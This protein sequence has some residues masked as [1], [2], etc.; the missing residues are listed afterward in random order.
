MTAT[1]TTEYK[2]DIHFHCVSFTSDPAAVASDMYFTNIG[3]A[4]E[5][6]EHKVRHF[7]SVMLWERGHVGRPGYEDV[8]VAYWWTDHLAK[9]YNFGTREGR[10][11]GWVSWGETKLPTDLKTSTHLYTPL[12]PAHASVA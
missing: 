8:W 6:A 7:S 10:G 11:K 4:K 5:F 3:E 12:D 2:E 1:G 9:V